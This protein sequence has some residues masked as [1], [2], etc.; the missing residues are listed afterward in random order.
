[1]RSLLH[2]TVGAL[3][4]AAS[5]SCSREAPTSPP[6]AAAEEP[7]GDASARAIFQ[8]R[9]L[10]IFQAARPSSCTECHLSGVEL[11]DYI[12]PSQ[13]ETFTALVAA[14]LVDEKSPERSKILQFI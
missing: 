3:L 13:E 10:P 9:I 5:S 8:Q 1:M 12:R 6:A 4:L 2:L 11:K 14:G 7:Q